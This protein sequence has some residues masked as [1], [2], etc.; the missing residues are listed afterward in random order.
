MTRPGPSDPNL[1]SRERDGA[2]TGPA[3][4]TLNPRTAH[5]APLVTFTLPSR[6]QPEVPDEAPGE[7]DLTRC[8]HTQS[9]RVDC[10]WRLGRIGRP[11]VFR[12]EYS[13]HKGL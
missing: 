5:R 10:P 4:A 7:S 12:I 2:R 6:T 8:P 9:G 3:R 1:Q 13:W 11:I